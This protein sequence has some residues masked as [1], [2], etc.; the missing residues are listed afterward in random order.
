MGEGA[1]AATGLTGN[2]KM[3]NGKWE[4]EIGNSKLCPPSRTPLRTTGA[5]NCDA[6]AGLDRKI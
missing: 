2:W 5:P 6:E 1:Q 3:E 4:L